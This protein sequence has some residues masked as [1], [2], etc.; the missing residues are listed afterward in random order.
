LIIRLA[1]API[2][3]LRK[4]PFWAGQMA[5]KMAKLFLDGCRSA[6]KRLQRCGALKPKVSSVKG[7]AIKRPHNQRSTTP[8]VLMV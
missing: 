1:F 4:L 3:I 2:S 8:P 5:W 7:F 6:A